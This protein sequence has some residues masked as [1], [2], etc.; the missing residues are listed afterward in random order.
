MYKINNKRSIVD[1]L[2]KYDHLENDDSAFIELTEW[3]NGEGFDIS[4]N[5]KII[6]LTNGQI[7]AI[8]HLKNVLDYQK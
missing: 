5:D 8:M 1:N 3:A 6:S 7:E 2:T 4:I